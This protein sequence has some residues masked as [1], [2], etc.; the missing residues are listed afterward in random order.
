VNL[1]GNRFDR[2]ELAGAFGD[3]GTRVP[4]VVGYITIARLDP[5]GMLLGFRLL[6]LAT[7]FYFRTPMLVQP[8]K[9][10]ATVAVTQPQ[11]VTPGAIFASA[12]HARPAYAREAG[13]D[14][15]RTNDAGAGRLRRHRGDR[16]A[17]RS[18]S[19]HR[20]GKVDIERLRQHLIDMNEA[21]AVVGQADARSRRPRHGDHRYGTD[22]AGDPRDGGAARGRARPH[23]FVRGQLRAKP[24]PVTRTEEATVPRIWGVSA[25]AA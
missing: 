11:M 19:G 22:R 17:P 5:Q 10:I 24:L 14:R 1:G 21:A 23:V 15:G 3:L 4:F 12:R 8:M 7:S 25:R 16:T 9:A 20:L 2:S 6:A 13:D 18:G